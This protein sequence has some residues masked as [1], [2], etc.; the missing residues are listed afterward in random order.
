MQAKGYKY[1]G[2]LITEN[3]ALQVLNSEHVKRYKGL[4]KYNFG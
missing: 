1:S 4:F 2:A 3:L